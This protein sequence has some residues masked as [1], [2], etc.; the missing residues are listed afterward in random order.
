[1]ISVTRFGVAASIAYLA[2]GLALAVLNPHLHA[3]VMLLGAVG[4]LVASVAYAYAG[5]VRRSK[6][7]GTAGPLAASLA[8][9]VY[10][11]DARGAMIAAGVGYLV[12]S[13][14]CASAGLSS[15]PGTARLSLLA[16]AY[17]LASSGLYSLYLALTGLSSVVEVAYSLIL[18]LPVQSIVSVT[19]HALPSTYRSRPSPFVVLSLPLLTL[20]A[21]ARSLSSEVAGLAGATGLAVFLATTGFTRLPQ[22]AKRI[23]P[24]E[25]GRA[26]RYFILGHVYAAA[27]TLGS[28]AA[29]VAH[30]FGALGYL[31]L[32]HVLLG[33]MAASYVSIHAPLMLPVILRI[34]T[35]R[36]YSQLP[37]VLAALGTLLW[38]LGY[39]YAALAAYAAWSLALLAIVKPLTRRQQRP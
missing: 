15:K 18:L 20:A 17:S 28:L 13:Y 3:G 30:G 9:L 37:Y 27:A 21:V 19:L 35:A 26:H 32:V 38:L 31:E 7:Y 8:G 16:L 24:G 5:A 2:L 1:M 6:P 29:L 25:P 10:L 34:A 12:L 22:L 36:R 14:V 11:V 39:R 23:P 33:W 4:S